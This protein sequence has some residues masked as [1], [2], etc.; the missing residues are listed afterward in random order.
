[1]WETYKWH[2]SQWV[3]CQKLMR[4]EVQ[5][6]SYPGDYSKAWSLRICP[7]LEMESPCGMLVMADCQDRVL[8]KSTWVS[9]I[10]NKSQW[11]NSPKSNSSETFLRGR[12]LPKPT[13]QENH[14]SARF[15]LDTEQRTCGL[16]RWRKRNCDK[17]LLNTH[18]R[19]CSA[20]PSSCLLC[21]QD[22]FYFS[23]N[24]LPGAP[25]SIH[26]MN[27]WIRERWVELNMTSQMYG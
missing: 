20:W 23:R 6:L 4:E 17:T 14:H 15:P 18:P 1:M 2:G 7:Q 16:L 10:S 19:L 9:S 24:L 26:A 25:N 13:F 21:L 3:I 12:L 8:C 27:L 5:L 11:A 22:F